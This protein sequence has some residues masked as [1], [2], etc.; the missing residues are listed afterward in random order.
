MNKL[1]L[2]KNKYKGI[3][4]YC[5][6]CK[7]DNPKCKHFERFSYKV[8]VHVP[9]TQRSVKSKILKSK[10]Y[11]EAVIEAINFEK[12]LKETNYQTIVVDSTQ[13]NDYS[14]VDSVIK[15][16]H[17]LNGDSEYAQFKKNITDEHRKELIR[18]CKY[19]VKT[20][21]KNKNIETTRI[22]D[23]SRQDVSNFYTW[24][25]NHY[26]PK[27][28]NKCM[29]GVKGF[30][31]F[32]IDIEEIE[33]KNPF[34]KYSRKQVGKSNIDTVTREEFSAILKAVDTY[35][36][37]MVL[38]GRGERKNMFKSYLKDGFRLFLLT[39]GRREEIVDLRWSDIYV[40]VSG[41]KFF[42]IQNLKVERSRN[43]DGLYKYIPINSDLFDLLVEMGYD[44]KKQSENYILLPDRKVQSK[45]IM[46]ALSK[47]FTHYK[48][49]AGIKKDISL[50]SLRKTYISWVHQVMQKETGLL[51]SHSTEKVLESYY[52][53]PQ[54]LSVVEKGAIEIK[55]FGNDSSL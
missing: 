15:Y 43:I 37:F 54:I 12:H 53:D 7:V 48:N 47:S 5:K 27:T 49:G 31:D 50:K 22:I 55:I 25:E 40:S 34:R 1:V 23:V 10:V 51:T 39:G 18:F 52:I 30:F 6:E 26:S 44:E 24:A 9:G 8:R 32:L 45:T 14:V 35:S 16:N 4:I 17:Y 42:R 41:V 33:M 28:F 21:K 46:D 2:P 38:G 29:N 11:S 19:F 3:K 36:P 20:L 13:G